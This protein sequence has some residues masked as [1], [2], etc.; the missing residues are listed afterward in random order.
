MIL[1]WKV[2]LDTMEN[3]QCKGLTLVEIVVVISILAVLI[4][5]IIGPAEGCRQRVRT[6]TCQSNLKQLFV[7]FQVYEF[8]NGTFPSAFYGDP[9]L[10]PPPTGFAG[11]AACDRRGWW[12]FDYLDLSEH[13]DKPSVLWCPSRKTNHWRIDNILHGNYGVNQSVCRRFSSSRREKGVIGPPLSSLQIPNPTET[14]LLLD[15]GYAAIAWWHAA[16][17]SP[18]KL[19][20]EVLDTAY[21]PGMTINTN[22]KLWP[23]QHADAL[24][25]RHF[26]R[27]VNTVL[28]DGHVEARPSENLT[29]SR[30]EAKYENRCPLWIP[31]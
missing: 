13:I 1:H 11:N 18:H 2:H 6:V 5:V 24:H 22:K 7:S 31:E 17:E 10:S 9:P 28:A 27:R 26:S 23:G 14:L 19:S 21:V 8:D 15:S 12:W 25:G 30:G 16:D 20:S 3:M 29:V 4:T